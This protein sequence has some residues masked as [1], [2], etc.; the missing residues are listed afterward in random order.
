MTST[1][2]WLDH[3]EAQR[4]RM[5]EVIDLFREKGT[6]DELGFGTI[7]DSFSDHFFPGISTL[8]TRAR[9]LLFVPWVYQRIEREKVP[10][11]QVDERARHS[12]ALVARALQA[13][14]EGDAQGVIGI[15]AGESV[16]RTPAVVYWTSFRRFRIWRFPGSIG[17]YYA[18]LK[19]AGARPDAVR[20]DDG[21]LVEQSGLRGWHQG[22]PKEPHGL[23]DRTT[24]DL[25]PEEADYLRERIV[26]EVPGTL[27]A[28]VVEGRQ[29]ISRIDVPWLHP[30]RSGF[31]AQLQRDLDH[32]HRFAMV[33]YGAVIL[34]NLLVA[35]K[36]AAAELPIAK[37]LVERYRTEYGSW[38]DEV[39]AE[40]GFVREWNLDDLWV[41]VMGKGHRIAHPTRQFLETWVAIVRH[42]VRSAP[43][44]PG[45]RRMIQ[46]RELFLKGGLARLTHRRAL[47]RFG[48]SAGLYRQNYRWPNVRRIVGDIHAGLT[49]KPAGATTETAGDART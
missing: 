20:S 29:R 34:Y 32:A 10:W 39:E 5:L 21:E 23:L 15:Q 8:Q 22:L 45:L 40:G 6:V 17:Q 28:F 19:R 30:D 4:R 26:A 33:S 27:L 47:E 41:T 37:G 46:Q 16:Q 11:P 25:S 31:P 38:S 12:Q 1:F 35:E 42:E 2:A 13:G 9:Y 18:S 44:H 43:D 3:S 7:R 49:P 48:G 24:F 14:G 36:A